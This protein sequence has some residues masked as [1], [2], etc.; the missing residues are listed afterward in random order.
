MKLH[1]IALNIDLGLEEQAEKE[2]ANTVG[3][4]IT[5]ST[6][7]SRG[8]LFQAPVKICQHNLSLF[9]NNLIFMM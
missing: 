2:T 3:N 9:G 5:R 1:E 6:F 7:S 8:S 4:T